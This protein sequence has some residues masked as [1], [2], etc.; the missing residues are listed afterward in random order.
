MVNN[1]IST[2]SSVPRFYD[3]VTRTPLERAEILS[4]TLQNNVYLKREELQPVHSF[5]LR[6][7]YHMMT[8]LSREQLDI[9]VIAA[10]AG[11][12]A[13]GVAL[14]A[15][16]LD[17]TAVIVMP[18]TTPDI[19][20]QA[21]KRYGGEVVLHGTCYSDAY[22]HCLELME[23]SGCTFV[24]PFNNLDVIEGQGTVATEILEQLPGADYI[25]VPVGGGGL[26]AGIAK[27][28]K[29]HNPD[30]KIIGVEPADSN[31]MTQA[32]QAGHPVTLDHVGLFADGVAV[33]QVGDNSFA[34]A[35]K[36]V[37]DM[38]TVDTTQICQAIKAVFEENR[39]I[40]EAAG[41]L[42]VAGVCEYV[43][44]HEVQSKNLVAVCSGANINFDT[45]DHIVDQLKPE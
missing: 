11:N 22:D 1:A 27:V 33:K 24:H 8:K 30:V 45:L 10:S 19:K 25:F 16:L 41:A 20:V 14:S 36:Y 15:R 13:Q 28:A 26:I 4:S 37:D 38:V 32:L 31:A 18:E 3:V 6:G 2:N 34:L 12:H 17:S 9:G 21:V 35:S 40:L 7:A 42:A 29:Q 5:K 44:T 23:Q 43:R 39:T